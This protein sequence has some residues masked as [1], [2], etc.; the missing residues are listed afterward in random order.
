MK[1]KGITEFIRKLSTGYTMYFN[2]RYERNGVL[3]Q[4]KFKASLIQP[5][6]FL[7]LSAYVNCNS[8]VHGI[9]RAEVY[10]WCSFPE[11]IGKRSK[12]LCESGKKIILDD[13]RGGE[14][15]KKF[16]KE[17][18]KHFREK[19]LDERIILED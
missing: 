7:Y 18:A 4:G 14:D 19:K 3:F 17:N 2:K 5:S 9:A 1:D 11:Y 12:G 10:R 6:N 8:E 13:F 16:A 15:Y